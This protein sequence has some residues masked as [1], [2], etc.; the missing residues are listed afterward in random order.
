MKKNAMRYWAKTVALVLAGVT[1]LGGLEANADKAQRVIEIPE[2]TQIENLCDT[3]VL[4]NYTVYDYTESGSGKYSYD[5]NG[6]LYYSK[7]EVIYEEDGYRVKKIYEVRPGGTYANAFLYTYRYLD[8]KT[9]GYMD[10]YDHGNYE[11]GMG[12]VWDADGREVLAVKYDEQGN[13]KSA[14]C[15]YYDAEGRLAFEYSDLSGVEKR[16]MDAAPVRSYQYRGDY[17]VYGYTQEHANAT[18]ENC[19]RKDEI[20]GKALLEAE[21][22]DELDNLY[23][24]SYDEE[25]K[26]LYEVICRPQ[27]DADCY[28][29]E[30][31]HYL[32]DEQGRCKESYCYDVKSGLF[33][34]DNGLYSGGYRNF[35]AV[36]DD[37]GYPTDIIAESNDTEPVVVW[38]DLHTGEFI[39]MDM[40]EN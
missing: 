13:I 4:K 23:W 11:Y 36:F 31:I 26:L 39:D 18:A 5:E 19:Y 8:D 21:Y 20:D 1:C 2:N 12:W 14:D 37:G 35:V 22:T 9:L 30:L 38:F 6:E 17:T 24:Y 29:V 3:L 7:D 28:E 33:V 40:G 15:S 34:Q 27:W 10:K 16:N 32:Y 25:G